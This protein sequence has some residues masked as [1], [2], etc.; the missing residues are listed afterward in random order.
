MR[1]DEYTSVLTDLYDRCETEAWAEDIILEDD[2]F[3]SWIASDR[4]DS[5]RLRSA[6]SLQY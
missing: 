2:N 6:L 3:K 1:L 4:T 5:I